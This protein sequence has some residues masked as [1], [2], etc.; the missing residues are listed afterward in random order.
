MLKSVIEKI[1]Q[2]RSILDLFLAMDQISIKL[3]HH[4]C[5]LSFSIQ[6]LPNVLISFY[7]W[8]KLKEYFFVL[9]CQSVHE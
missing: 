4:V 3:V 9:V 7:V 5:N 6:L 2:R 1:S 8:V